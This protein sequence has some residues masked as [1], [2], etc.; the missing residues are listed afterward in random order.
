L[1]YWKKIFPY[2]KKKFPYWKKIFPYWKSQ[3]PVNERWCQVNYFPFRCT[4]LDIL[5]EKILVVEFMKKLRYYSYWI[6]K[7]GGKE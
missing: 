4:L 1:T 7:K 2:C 5:E 3:G 6:K